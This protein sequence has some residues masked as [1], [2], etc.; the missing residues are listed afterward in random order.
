MVST[1]DEEIASIARKYGA[2]IPFMR[3]ALNANDTAGTP[4][5]LVEVIKNYKEN[6]RHFS[7]GCCIYPTAPFITS[8]ILKKSYSLFQKKDFDTVFPVVQYS[9]PIQRALKVNVLQKVSMFYPDYLNSRS[10]DL[11]KSYHDAG[12][13]YWFRPAQL[14]I[15]N[16]MWTDN[17]GVIISSTKEVQD[18]DT[19]EDWKIAE[20]KY[21][22]LSER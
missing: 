3:S 1:D 8:S 13:F 19:E 22:I 14:E 5:V 18:I 12:Q 9:S 7:V 16:K 17:S 10:Q 15:Q 21:R 2:N 20:L 4:E 6:R 11:E